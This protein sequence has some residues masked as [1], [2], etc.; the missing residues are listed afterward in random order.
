VNSDESGYGEARAADSAKSDQERALERKLG[1]KVCAGDALST[2][3]ATAAEDVV[4]KVYLT[5]EPSLC[6]DEI[7]PGNVKQTFGSV[8]ACEKAQTDQSGS[9][10]SLHV[11]KSWGA[12]DV[13]FV[14]FTFQPSPLAIS[15]N[16]ALEG[17]T[18]E[19]QA[20]VYRQDGH[21]RLQ[22]VDVKPPNGPAS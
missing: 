17:Q 15:S 6:E 1:L 10:P 3:D 9:S 7:T 19:A 21:W 18:L 11:T 20:L 8:Q 22:H 16:P 4:K 12:G 5:S 13:V 2:K 14:Q